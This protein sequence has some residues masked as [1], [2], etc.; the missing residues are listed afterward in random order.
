MATAAGEVAASAP[1]AWVE[2]D[3]AS[4][5]GYQVFQ[6][7]VD[8][9]TPKRVTLR[10]LIFD[11]R[12]RANVSRTLRLV[13]DSLARAER[14]LVA[15]RAIA[16]APISQG[17]QRADLVPIAFGAWVPPEGWDS[18]GPA[19]RQRVHRTYVYVGTPPDSFVVGASLK[20]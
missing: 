16:Y 2:A 9:E 17:R 14:D 13:L 8:R 5:V 19:S 1:A 11:P 20:P 18:A 15:A 10:I 4:P 7:V 3:T 12:G 6:T